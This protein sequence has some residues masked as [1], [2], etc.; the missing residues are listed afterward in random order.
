[1]HGSQN[2]ESY[3]YGA[4]RDL[5]DEEQRATRS[6]WRLKL[7]DAD[8][9][10]SQAT[11]ESQTQLMLRSGGLVKEAFGYHLNGVWL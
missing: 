3:P 7:T 6:C 9:F 4:G 10:L 1:V 11:D 2:S 8:T 5:Y